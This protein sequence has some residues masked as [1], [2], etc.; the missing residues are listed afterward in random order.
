MSVGLHAGQEDQSGTLLVFNNLHRLDVQVV[1]IL[2][3]CFQMS[4]EVLHFVAGDRHGE[5]FSGES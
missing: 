5:I 3:S 1:V 2:G 4:C